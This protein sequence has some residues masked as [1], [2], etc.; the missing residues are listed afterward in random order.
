MYFMWNICVTLQWND[1]E[2]SLWVQAFE[3]LEPQQ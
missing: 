3:H 1:Y 2:L